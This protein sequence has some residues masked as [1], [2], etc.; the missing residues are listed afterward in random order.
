M[1]ITDLTLTAAIAPVTH[2]LYRDIH[3]AI[4]V[5]LFAVTTEAGR[6]DPSVGI[7]RASLATHVSDVVEL[8]VAH[9]EH[10]DGAVQPVLEARLPELAERV[11]VDHLTLEARLGDL[12][13]M[14]AEA[15]ALEAP[16]PGAQVH[17]LYLALAAFTSAYLEHQDIE[18]RVVMPALEAAIGADEVVTLHQAILA[19]IPPDE[20]AR[21]LALMIP[22]MN[23]DN[24]VDMLGGMRAE[25]PAEVFD[26]VWGLVGSVLDPADHKA[27]AKRL[28][29]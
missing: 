16:D 29:I 3:K 26:G 7:A 11:A 2:D 14:A 23:I 22:A 17:R 20:M 12:N 5:E 8:L 28:G 10:E 13:A 27:L 1:T 21:S 18:E 25:A 9:A 24:R 19:A 4:R 6:L 15:A